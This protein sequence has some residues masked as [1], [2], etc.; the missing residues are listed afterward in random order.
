MKKQKKVLLITVLC[1]IALMGIAYATF[2]A[3]TLK[4][5]TSATASAS[6]FS[7]GFD[8]VEPTIEKSSDNIIVSSTTPTESDE[9][10]TLS[11]SGLKNP[12]DT[13][14]AEY[15]ILNNGDIDATDITIVTGPDRQMEVGQSPQSW[16]SEDGVF[17]FGVYANAGGDYVD[18]YWSL[19]SPLT[20]KAGEKGR[21]RIEVKLLKRV[22]TETTASCTAKLTANPGNLGVEE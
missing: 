5:N 3:L 15:T 22:D 9:E 8:D 6:I 21:I 14:S 10:I 2:T 16:T 20:L 7:I 4:I 17:E 19:T 13:A 11:F 12:G 1:V 18:G